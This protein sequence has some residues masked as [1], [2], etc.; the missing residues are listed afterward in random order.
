VPSCHTSGRTNP[1][2]TN[3]QCFF[4][5]LWGGRVPRL[6][7]NGTSDPLFGW[8][9]IHLGRLAWNCSTESVIFEGQKRICRVPAEETL[10]AGHVGSD[11]RH[12]RGV[13]APRRMAEKHIGPPL[14]MF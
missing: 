7:T 9:S 13:H 14:W 6:G 11:P 1:P 2:R 3:T 5:M 10:H 8:K 12:P 4:A